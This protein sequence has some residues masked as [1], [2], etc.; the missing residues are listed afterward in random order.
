MKTQWLRLLVEFIAVSAHARAAA[1]RATS[2][3]AWSAADT[4]IRVAP[5]TVVWPPPGACL[6]ALASGMRPASGLRAAPSARRS[7]GLFSR[8]VWRLR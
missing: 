8:L 1:A 7:L 3:A 5:A 4:A 6:I 2:A